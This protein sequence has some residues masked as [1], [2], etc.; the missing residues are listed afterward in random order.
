MW[1]RPG[2]IGGDDRFRV[3]SFKSR[4]RG[5]KSASDAGGSGSGMASKSLDSAEVKQIADISG[6]GGLEAKH[7]DLEKGTDSPPKSDADALDEMKAKENKVLLND[8]KFKNNRIEKSSS[9][10]KILVTPTTSRKISAPPAM[11]T[12]IANAAVGQKKKNSRSHSN[13]NLNSLL[14]YKSLLNPSQDKRLTSE[15]FDKMRRKS[16][17]EVAKAEKP[18]QCGGTKNSVKLL[19]H[20]ALDEPDD[21]YLDKDRDSVK[22]EASPVKTEKVVVTKLS[23]KQQKPKSI[24]KAKAIKKRRGS[25]RSLSG[26][27]SSNVPSTLLQLG[28]K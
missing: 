14:K 12:S 6:E 18:S 19:R 17:S 7:E 2:Q 5:R 22:K 8:R 20:E 26:S 25:K 15:E 24:S 13:L 11:E 10:S 28:N 21:V 1:F 23:D 16:L 9:R 27:S 4:I 3:S